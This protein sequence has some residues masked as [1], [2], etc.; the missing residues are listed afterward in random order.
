MG[1]DGWTGWSSSSHRSGR[2]F[3]LSWDKSGSVGV[4]REGGGAVWVGVTCGS[5]V[6]GFAK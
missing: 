6:G 3:L 2:G 1:G 4:V 5:W